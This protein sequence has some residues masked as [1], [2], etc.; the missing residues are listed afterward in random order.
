[1]VEEVIFNVYFLW[2]SISLS[3]FPFICLM[4]PLSKLYSR[5][6]LPLP[7]EQTLFQLSNYHL[8]GNR[9]QISYSAQTICVHHWIQLYYFSLVCCRKSQSCQQKDI[10]GLFIFLRRLVHCNVLIILW[11]VR[12]QQLYVLKIKV[13]L[14]LANE[15]PTIDYQFIQS[16]SC[17]NVNIWRN[18]KASQ[19]MF[20]FKSSHSRLV[21][22]PELATISL[23]IWSSSLLILK[24]LSLYNRV[25]VRLSLFKSSPINHNNCWFVGYRAERKIESRNS[26]CN[27][28][29]PDM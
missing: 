15:T 11:L 8:Q 10:R 19:F 6:M 14:Q 3:F 22:F 4:T 2:L 7:C 5:N 21:Y 16:V 20:L 27:S 12:W 25:Q 23:A 24:S 26:K 9:L 29:N 1:M 13:L 18:V 28:C 17:T